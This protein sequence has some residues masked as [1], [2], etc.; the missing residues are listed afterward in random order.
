[1]D[2]VIFGKSVREI[3][4]GVA[5]G[6]LLVAILCAAS[7]GAAPTAG[8]GDPASVENSLA[9]SVR[10]SQ[11]ARG[12]IASDPSRA[13]VLAEAAG[14]LAT[15]SGGASR[16]RALAIATSQWLRGE[17]ALRLDHPAVAKPL[18]AAALAAVDAE[19][20]GTEL[21]ADI[22]VSRARLESTTDQVQAALAD[23]LAAFDVYKQ[24]GDKRQ[25]AVTLQ[26]IGLL[27]NNA[28]DYKR[29]LSYYEQSRATYSG[30]PI[31]D[32]SVDNNRADS[33]KELGQFRE[34]ERDYNSAL[35]LAERMGSP[36]LEAQILSNLAV[37]QISDHQYD[38]AESSV[39]KGL[40][41]ARGE[42]ANALLPTLLSTRAQLYLQEGDVAEARAAI[43][44]IPAQAGADLASERDEWVHRTKYE[45]YKAE[46]RSRDALRELEIFQKIQGGHRLLMSSANT[47]LMAARFDFDNQNAR[48][49]ALKTGELRRD[50]ALTRLRARQG[51][52]ALGG[53]LGIVTALIVF[54]VLYVRTLRR[55]HRQTRIINA[56]LSESN[57]KLENALQAKTMFLATTSHE[58]RTPLN[59]V[60]GM[61]EVLLAEK[62]LSERV[63][64]RVALI[65]GAGEAM[66]ILVDD[67]LDMSKMDAGQIVLQRE[68]VDLSSL[69]SEISRFWL[70]HAESA[71]LELILDISDAPV[72]IVEDARRLRQILSNLLSNAVKFTPAG[73]IVLSARAREAGGGEQLLIQVS[74]T[75]IGILDEFREMI[76]DKFTQL[77]TSITRK[78]A[79]TGLGLSIARTL[80]RAMGGDITVESNPAGGADFLVTLP[81]ERAAID[82]AV[83]AHPADAAQSLIDL[84]ILIVEA[85][86][87]TQ[88]GLRSLLE[89][90]VDSLSFSPT[91]GEAIEAIGSSVTHVVIASFPKGGRDPD[92]ALDR[93]M[94]DLALAC[95]RAGVDLVIILDPAD[96]AGVR[97]LHLGDASYLERPVSAT[98]LTA[99]LESLR[100]SHRHVSARRA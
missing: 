88:G 63:R 60:L 73:T 26:D 79:G 40:R 23:Y 81:L 89:R 13:E 61:T 74:D 92:D 99:H 33:L 90:R 69:L 80:A 45:V 83:A 14:R 11:A 1:M 31:L 72:M 93:D 4:L 71:G 56:Q 53:L 10:L 67:L 22:L 87:I 94:T 86:P 82:D 42:A 35:R 30:V 62:E 91:I 41:L 85:N 44:A 52:I 8:S 32:L 58:I 27:Y 24:V 76:F 9:S 78:Y 97:S 68:V 96:L 6:F 64:Q 95:R 34:A 49:A 18:L 12:V 100:D 54:L 39:A 98:N 46:G 84:R 15:E 16:E 21:K 3:G 19:A 77:D 20:D 65:H 59:G 48:I 17:A 5:G 55:S 43:D 57:A 37:A 66:R 75:G 70:T 7:F 47:A 2:R 36:S 38:A 51:Q 28:G 29:A 25:Q 50:I